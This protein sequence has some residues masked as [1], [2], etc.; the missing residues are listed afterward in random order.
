MEASPNAFQ[1]N[2][3]PTPTPYRYIGT[4]LR[5][6][7]YASNGVVDA[8][9]FSELKI[10]D[11]PLNDTQ[12]RFSVCQSCRLLRMT[13]QIYDII[14]KLHWPKSGT[15]K[16]FWYQTSAIF[17][18]SLSI[19]THISLSLASSSC[20]CTLRAAVR[21]RLLFPFSN[22]AKSGR[23]M[24]GKDV[25]STA[26]EIGTW[27]LVFWLVQE[28]ISS[29]YPERVSFDGIART[30]VLLCPFRPHVL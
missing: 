3:Q 14:F 25:N 29:I 18:I 27:F 8:V 10:G 21:F 26:W 19:G 4:L 2:K 24:S 23:V 28:C 15:I 22:D 17:N 5:G 13:S 16:H 6:W 7:I 11:F 9:S 30:T 20:L 12:K 1:R